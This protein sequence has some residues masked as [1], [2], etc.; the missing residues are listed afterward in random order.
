M[1]GTTIVQVLF[2]LG[3]HQRQMNRL[4]EQAGIIANLRTAGV[5]EE[6]IAHVALLGVHT[7]EQLREFGKETE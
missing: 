3:R 1:I 2:G 7:L 6:M 4:Q 5:N